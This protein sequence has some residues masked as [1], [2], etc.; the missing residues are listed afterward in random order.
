MKKWLAAFLAICLFLSACGKQSEPQQSH[1]EGKTV[2]VCLAGEEDDTL[3]EQLQQQ[4][5][6]L[7]FAAKLKYAKGD[8][9]EQAVQ[10]EQLLRN[11]DCLIV[12][13]VD[14]LTL[15]EAGETAKEKNVPI[16]ACDTLL[17]DTQWVWGCVSYDYETLGAEMAKQVVAAKKLD[18]KKSK[19]T[20]EFFMGTTE[21]HSALL[22]HKGAMSVFQPYLDSGRLTCLS[23]RVSFEDS[24]VPGGLKAQ[25][26]TECLGRLNKAYGEKKLDICFAGT[27]EI[28]AGCRTALDACGY[29]RENWPVLIGQGGQNS[30]AV[31]DGY[32]LCTYLK[33][34]FA[35]ARQCAEFALAAVKGEDPPKETTVS[36]HV[37]EVP[38]TYLPV[39]G[40]FG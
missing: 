13:A 32:Q 9:K 1:G 23:G 21:D 7:G 27:D 12:Q 14:S 17:M 24:Y 10:A 22:L 28:A 39:T 34:D 29:T 30:Q 18:E 33:D 26:E 4:L 2:G 38:V 31:K 11:V 36:N 8:A 5:Q 19:A 25:A 20:I 15:L 35:L 3:A 37:K 6:T 16:I 40:V